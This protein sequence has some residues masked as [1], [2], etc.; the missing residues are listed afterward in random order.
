[1]KTEISEIIKKHLP[2]QV[3]ELLKKELENFKELR[4]EHD[5]SLKDID[6]KEKTIHDL[7]Q[8]L[9]ALKCLNLKRKE[10][11]VREL[12]IDDKERNLKVDVLDIKLKE[13]EKRADMAMAFTT[14]LIRNTLYRENVFGNNTHVL[15]DGNGYQR[16]EQTPTNDIKEKE[17]E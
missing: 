10:L 9:E 3:G 13:S 12:E 15:S 2:E 1:M 14:G 6:Q 16:R 11:D 4:G 7:R 5:Q 8:E 17:A